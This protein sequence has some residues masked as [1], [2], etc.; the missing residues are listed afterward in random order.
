MARAWISTPGSWLGSGARPRVQPLVPREHAAHHPVE[1]QRLH[2]RGFAQDR[3]AETLG[4][5]RQPASDLTDRGDEVPVVPHRRRKERRLDRTLL[6]E[7]VQRLARNGTAEGQVTVGDVREELAERDRVDDGA[8]DQVRARVLPLLDHGD[9]DV[10]EPLLH[11]RGALEQLGEADGAREARG[12]GPHEQHAHVDPVLGTGLGDVQEL[13]VVDLGPVVAG[14]G[15]HAV[16][17]GVH[18]GSVPGRKPGAFPRGACQP[19]SPALPAA[20][21]GSRRRGWTGS[22][23]GPW[24]PGPTA[25]PGGTSGPGR[26]RAPR[27]RAPP[28]RA[29][30]AAA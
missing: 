18:E 27:H 8:R 11:L 20:A 30:G 22:S 2:G 12:P 21:R 9:G 17:R 3:D 10:A 28:G 6:G 13:R 14:Y 24:A 23:S 25:R 1:D 4:A 26:S 29:A 7:Q 16:L 19:A 15:R 5:L